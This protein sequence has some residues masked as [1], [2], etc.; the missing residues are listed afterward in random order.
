MCLE[1]AARDEDAA[2]AARRRLT[3]GGPAL[4]LVSQSPRI[5]PCSQLDTHASILPSSPQG[6]R[7]ASPGVL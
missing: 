6:S 5:V 2:S 4:P 3:G 1:M 7:N